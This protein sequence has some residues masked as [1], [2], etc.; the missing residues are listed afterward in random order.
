LGLLH[1]IVV[2]DSPE[3]STE[4]EPCQQKASSANP[5]AAAA[6]GVAQARGLAPCG[7]LESWADA[8]IYAVATF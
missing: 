6:L 5:V 4:R 7:F 8:G 2:R 1:D 3:E